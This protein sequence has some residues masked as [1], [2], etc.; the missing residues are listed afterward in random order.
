MSQIQRTIHSNM[1]AFSFAI[2]AFPL[3]VTGQPTSAVIAAINAEGRAIED[4][5]RAI[6][7]LQNLECK[8]QTIPISFYS[9]NFQQFRHAM[10]HL[11]NVFRIPLIPWK[12]SFDQTYSRYLHSCRFPKGTNLERHCPSSVVPERFCGLWQKH[13]WGIFRPCTSYL[14]LTRFT[15]YT[16]RQSEHLKAYGYLCNVT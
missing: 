7:E 4:L 12:S 3:I 9:R 5:A 14:V 8:I 13:L 16:S 1:M 2:L 15:W 10:H 6:P 11:T